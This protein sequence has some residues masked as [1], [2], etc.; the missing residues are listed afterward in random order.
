[1]R[2]ACAQAD[3]WIFL[4]RIAASTAFCCSILSQPGARH[5]EARRP[6]EGGTWCA[7]SFV[8]HE[9]RTAPAA[10]PAGKQRGKRCRSGVQGAPQTSHDPGTLPAPRAAWQ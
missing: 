8:T 9:R 5:P 3:W 7:T 4:S 1:V 2:L 10:R 6:P